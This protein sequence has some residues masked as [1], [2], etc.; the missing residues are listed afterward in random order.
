[1]IV[2]QVRVYLFTFRERRR[3][4][5]VIDRGLERYSRVAD[6]VAVPIHQRQC[7]PHQCQRDAHIFAGVGESGVVTNNRSGMSEPNCTDMLADGLK[8]LGSSRY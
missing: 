6:A 7:H 8:L 4:P 3:S 1:M 2:D 5:H